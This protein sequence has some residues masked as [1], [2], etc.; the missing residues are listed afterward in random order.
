MNRKEKIILG[1][2]VAGLGASYLIIKS[3]TQKNI[4]NKILEAIGGSASN[5]SNYN[6]WFSPIYYTNYSDGG[7]IVLT[8]GVALEKARKLGDSFGFFTDDTDDILGVMRAIPDGVALSQ[9]AEKFE[10][11]GYGDLR[12]KIGDLKKSEVGRVGQILSEKPPFRK[13]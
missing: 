8:E 2:S 5:I 7:H 1:A 10:S 12:T 4:F 3:V 13:A 9:I 11:K 6:E